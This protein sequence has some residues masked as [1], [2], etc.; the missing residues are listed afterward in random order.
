MPQIQNALIFINWNTA[1][2]TISAVH[3]A[4]E[5][6]TADNFRI[7]I[8]DNGSSDG[9]TA[10]FAEELPEVDV[11]PLE[12]NVGFARAV[13]A[14]LRTVEE[15]F[16]FILN[17]DLIF[18]PG[19]F[20]Q[21]TEALEKYPDAV[22]ACPR[23]LRPDGSVQPAVVPEPRIFWELVNRSLPRHLLRLSEQEV[24]AVPSIVG[25]CMAVHMERMRRVGLMDERFFFFF[26]ET[27][28]CRRFRMAGLRILYVPTASV[29]HMQGET[30]NRRPIR[31]RIQFYSS[32]YRYFRKHN[33]SAAVAILAVG[34]F[35]KLNI[36]LFLHG[37]LTLLFLG[38]RRRR[39]RLAV[40]AA[41]WA[42]HL[43]GCPPGA[44]FEPDW[45]LP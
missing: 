3:S 14:G 11:V 12:R 42:W 36:S 34:L 2:M 20:E 30:A 35:L 24:Q 4:R 16:A 6:A 32:R 37:L 39:D 33:G 21:L 44:G 1:D 23:L 22:L 41:L 27:D 18:H 7:I 9:S 29:V 26:E 17:T 43:R 38:Q 45:F 40:Y 19:V 25:P 5:A 13:N 8:V 15:P 31:A 10:R 28:W